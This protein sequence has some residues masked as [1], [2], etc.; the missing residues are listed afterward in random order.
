MLREFPL[1]DGC[2]RR[3]GTEQ[4]GSRRR[5]A[6]IDRQDVGSHPFLRLSEPVVFETVEPLLRFAIPLAFRVSKAW[7]R[8]L[9]LPTNVCKNI[10]GGLVE[11]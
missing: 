4:H 7:K 5:R 3:I 11:A 1:G 8:M 9:A 6:L 2:D 10:M